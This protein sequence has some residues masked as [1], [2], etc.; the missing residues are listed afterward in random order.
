MLWMFPVLW[1]VQPDVGDVD[2]GAT[3]QQ[4]G[5][6]LYSL[7]YNANASEVIKPVSGCLQ[8]S[9]FNHWASKLFSAA[10][11][12]KKRHINTQNTSKCSI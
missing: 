3:K 10:V 7:E 12:L 4:R 6:L 2:Y 9:R 11:Q 1:Q 8:C 5:K